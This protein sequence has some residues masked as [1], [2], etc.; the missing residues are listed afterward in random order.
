MIEQY[1]ALRN[2]FLEEIPKHHRKVAQQP[3]VRRIRAALNNK[4]TLPTLYFILH[5]LEIF[6]KYKKLF[7]RSDTTIHLLYDKQIDLFRKTLLYFCHLEKIEMLKCSDTLLSFDYE[8]K[9]NILPQTEFSIGRNAK[10]LISEFAENDKTVFLQS[11]KYFFIKICNLLK[12]NLSLKNKFLANLRFLKPENKVIEGEKMI[13]GCASFMPP[14]TKFKSRDMDALSI[15]WKQLIL[16]DVPEVRKTN[17]HICVRDYWKTVFELKD[18]GEPKFPLIQ[19]VVWF[20]LSIAEANAEV[21]RLFSQIFHIVN[22]DRNRLSTHSIKGLL[23]TKS[24]IQTIGTCLNF[25][26]RQ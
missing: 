4:F 11:I 20:A 2:L 19:K 21:E 22:K 12:K 25:K 23:V 5:A 7:Q 24:Y 16:E 6:Q 18:A 3:R 14:I 13:L 8:N 26:N 10:K 15:E 17:D 9:D 1:K